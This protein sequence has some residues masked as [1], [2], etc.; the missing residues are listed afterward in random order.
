[1]PPE[2]MRGRPVPGGVLELRERSVKPL[3]VVRQMVDV[4]EGLDAHLD[5]A[6]VIKD[7]AAAIHVVNDRG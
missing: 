1:M 7:T 5:L 4:R 6:G 2:R 3:G